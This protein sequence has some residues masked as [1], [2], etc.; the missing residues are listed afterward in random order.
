M[1]WPPTKEGGLMEL[2]SGPFTLPTSVTTAWEFHPSASRTSRM[3][4]A[5]AWTGVATTTRS[6]PGSTP[7]SDRAPSSTAR[8]ATPGPL[9]VPVTRQP[10]SRS[11]MPTEPP[12]RPVPKIMARPGNQV[13]PP[14][15]SAGPGPSASVGEVVTESV[16]A[17]EVDVMDVLAGALRGDVEHDPDAPGHRTD[18]GQLAGADQGDG[19]E[20]HRPG[21]RGREGGHDVL[22]GGEED[23]D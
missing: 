12:M 7:S 16:G 15:L 18:D 3:T 20:S 19:T 21:R 8:A 14:R 9:S 22:G 11:A 5:A 17:L 13:R 1:G 4:T 6:A 2:T 23:R 10:R